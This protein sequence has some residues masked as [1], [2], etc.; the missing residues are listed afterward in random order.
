M[1]CLLY[2]LYLLLLFVFSRQSLSQLP[3][4][5]CIGAILAHCN[6]SL[7]GSRN[8]S[9]SASWVAGITGMHHH[10][11][12][13][14]IFLVKMGVSSCWPGWHELLTSRD[15]PALTSQ[16]AGITNTSH[17]AWLL[18]PSECLSIKENFAN[19]CFYNHTEYWCMQMTTTKYNQKAAPQCVLK[20]GRKYNREKAPS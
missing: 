3:G 14:F 10:Y 11:Q 15:L 13:I 17:W 20:G 16:S 8:S 12:L 5:E 2:Y 9:L 19:N 1:S 18:L 4:L 7:L 6:L